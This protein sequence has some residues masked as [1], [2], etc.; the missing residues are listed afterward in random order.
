MKQ[1]RLGIL[2]GRFCFFEIA[3]LFATAWLQPSGNY[4]AASG[5]RSRN[6]RPEA[7]K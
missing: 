5:R 1:K 4:Q 6:S 7:W 3:N 2:P